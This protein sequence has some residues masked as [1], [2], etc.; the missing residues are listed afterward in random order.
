MMSA[1]EAAASSRRYSLPTCGCTQPVLAPASR[2][3]CISRHSS[4]TPH[5]AG[6]FTVTLKSPIDDL[7]LHCS[8]WWMIYS[9]N[10]V[11]DGRFTV[12]L[13][14]LMDDLQL[15]CSPWWMIY[16]YTTV[17]DGWFTVTLQSLMDDLHLLWSLLN[18]LHLHCSAW[19]FTFT[20]LS[21]LGHLHLHYSPPLDDLHLHYSPCWTVYI[22]TA[23]STGRF[24][25]TL[26]SLLDHLHLHYSPQWT[27][28]SYIIVTTGP[29]FTFTLQSPMDNLH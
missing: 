12:T 24:T 27:I 3:A 5:A 21:L 17:P 2:K 20:L 22:Y 25:F 16:S 18:C 11:P 23:V 29:L 4:C 19:P 10:A 15:Y 13:Q 1:W 8:P 7:Q 26:Q 9:Y 28:Y 6:P 14:S